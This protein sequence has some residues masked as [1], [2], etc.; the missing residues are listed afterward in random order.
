MILPV[1]SERKQF[2]NSFMTI[3]AVS[4]NQATLRSLSTALASPPF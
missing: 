3:F 2:R 4:M 1:P